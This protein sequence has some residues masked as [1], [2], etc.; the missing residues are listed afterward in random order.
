MFKVIGDH[1]ICR[2]CIWENELWGLRFALEGGGAN[3]NSLR[4]AQLNFADFGA[5][6]RRLVQ[7]CSAPLPNDERDPEW[8]LISPDDDFEEHIPGVTYGPAYP[9]SNSVLYYWESSFWRKQAHLA[10]YYSHQM[11]YSRRWRQAP[12]QVDTVDLDWLAAAMAEASGDTTARTQFLERSHDRVSA[13]RLGLACCGRDTAIELAASFTDSELMDLLPELV[14]LASFEH[15]SLGKVHDLIL[16][17][18]R[19]EAADVV[20]ELVFRR[21]N[22]D[23][24]LHG[25]V[26][27]YWAAL[28]DLVHRYLDLAAALDKGFTDRVWSWAIEH[29]DAGVRKAAREIDRP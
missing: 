7:Y 15:H 4:E 8:R 10:A 24:P 12:Q 27:I 1:D 16:R 2:I 9:L 28:P 26:R 5:W 13:I 25:W 22:S 3:K 17:L 19:E 18:P 20:E 23:D 14:E 11:R 6:E 21:L 29:G